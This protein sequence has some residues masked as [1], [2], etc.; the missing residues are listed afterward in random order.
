M[1]KICSSG[2]CSPKML[3][4]DV[5]EAIVDLGNSPV[6]FLDTSTVIGFERSINLQSKA[7]R[8]QS[9]AFYSIISGICPRV[10]V[11]SPILAEMDRHS[12][13]T[14]SGRPEISQA[15]MEV[16]HRFHINLV[17][18]VRNARHTRDYDSVRRDVYWA[19]L[20]AFP[21]EHKKSCCDGISSTDRDLVSSAID[22]RYTENITGSLVLSCDAH[23]RGTIDV[24]TDQNLLDTSEN[25]RSFLGT[26]NSSTNETLS[27]QLF[28]NFEFEG[29][30]YKDVKTLR[31]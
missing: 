10:F 13:V 21:P 15:T 29:F 20:M 8:Y 31:F 30:G 4:K 14:R 18:F 19:S 22:S 26:L 24:L 23:I 6:I 5:S 17:N 25:L 16:M 12:R 28:P 7:G 3:E 2:F 9:D 1:S 27:R 11:T